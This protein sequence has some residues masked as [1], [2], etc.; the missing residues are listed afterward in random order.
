MCRGL[1]V[2]FR[3]VSD[4]Q[5]FLGIAIEHRKPAALHL[6][7]QLVPFPECMVDIGQGETDPGD[8]AWFERPRILKTVSEFPPHDVPSHQHLKLRQ[9]FVG[10]RIDVDQFDHP[11]CVCTG[12]RYIEIHLNWA[13]NRQLLFEYGPLVDQD[14]LSLRREA[15]IVDHDF[16]RPA[17]DI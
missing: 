15:L 17:P 16:S 7:H 5:E 11:I 9:A 2:F 4:R 8:H 6:H 13:S 3:R 1:K 10:I 12:R 14:I